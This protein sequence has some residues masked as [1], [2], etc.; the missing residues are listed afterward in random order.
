MLS[1]LARQPQSAGELIYRGQ[2]YPNDTPTP[3]PE[4]RYERRVTSGGKTTAST[5]ISR[6][7]DGELA[8]IHR[9]EHDDAYRLQHF[10]EL[11]AQ[12]GTHGSVDIA[13][14]RVQFRRV[15]NGKVK[16]RTERTALPVAVGPTLFGL[17]RAHWNELDDGAAIGIRFADVQHARSFAFTLRRVAGDV[18]TTTITMSADSRLMRLAIPTMRMVFD[19]SARTVQSY[20]GR[21]PPMM[22]RGSRYAPVVARVQYRQIAARYR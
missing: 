5:H 19:T 7:R 9:A 13:D 16:T 18:H 2:A 11:Q 15:R 12:T 14:G 3:E 10:E 8:V 1:E 21:I 22:R 17:I 4:F 6:D 20:Q